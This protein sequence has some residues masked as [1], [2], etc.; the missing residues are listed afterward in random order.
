MFE[1]S[2]RERDL[3]AR[4]KLANRL[5]SIAA[6]TED[7]FSGV[8]V[9]DSFLLDSGLTGVWSNPKVSGPKELPM[10]P[11]FW[12]NVSATS[13]YKPEPVKTIELKPDG[14]RG[15]FLFDKTDVYG[16]KAGD[17]NF[18]YK[19]FHTNLT[20]GSRNVSSVQIGEEDH[21]RTVGVD[22]GKIDLFGVELGLVVVET[23]Y[24]GDEGLIKRYRVNTIPLFDD[25][26]YKSVFDPESRTLG[27]TEA[28]ERLFASQQRA[29]VMLGDEG[30]VLEAK[31]KGIVKTKAGNNA[32]LEIQPGKID[33][34]IENLDIRTLRNVSRREWVNE[35]AM[36]QLLRSRGSVRL[37]LALQLR[38]GVISATAE[39]V[40]QNG[41]R[42][43]FI[44]R[45]RGQITP[46]I[47]YSILDTVTLK[48]QKEEEP[49][50]TSGITRGTSQLWTPSSPEDLLKGHE[51]RIDEVPYSS[52]SKAYTQNRGGDKRRKGRNRTR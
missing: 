28:E 24:S 19:I 42:S 49:E 40:N 1:P 45:G 17:G 13:L 11:V 48:E 34:L 32:E 31:A 23:T 38:N 43:E 3:T 8:Y 7:G 30:N 14:N 21:M 47:V 20:S 51:T 26:D 41:G 9:L 37:A 33:L 22:S 35:D 25:I 12:L 18:P 4:A 46:D 5:N 39:P 6:R 15:G 27:F 10:A 52:D 50:R 36:E 16:V 2:R 29:L 44:E